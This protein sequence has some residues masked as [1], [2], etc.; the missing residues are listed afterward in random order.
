MSKAA[1]VCEKLAATAAKEGNKKEQDKWQDEK[2][3]CDLDRQ[4]G[5]TAFQRYYDGGDFYAKNDYVCAAGCYEHV[6]ELKPEH[7]EQRFVRERLGTV[8]Q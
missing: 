2:K 6:L 4:E 8:S 3:R 1:A 7:H 5:M